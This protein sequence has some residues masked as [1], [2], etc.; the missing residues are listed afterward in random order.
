MTLEE[1]LAL[2]TVVDIVTAGRA[3]GVGRTTAHRLAR[4]GTFP[5]P[6]RQVGGSYRV[7]RADLFR[8]LGEVE[9]IPA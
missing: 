3:F 2:P 1:L 7:T 5:A 9:T 8:A 4:A 6:V